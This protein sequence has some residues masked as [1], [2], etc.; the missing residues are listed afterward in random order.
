M[1]LHCRRVMAPR[2]RALVLALLSVATAAIASRISVQAQDAVPR[3]APAAA[4][5]V[6][7]NREI[8]PIL[9]N[10]CFAC[11]GPDEKARKTRFHFDSR[12]AA[13]IKDGVIVPGQAQDSLLIQ[14]ITSTDPEE[15]MPP[16]DSGRSLTDKQV[17]LLKRWIDEGAKWDTHWAYVPPG[18]IEPPAITHAGWAR[19][20]IDRF[21]AARLEHEGLEPSPEAD[22]ET[23][24]RRVTFDLTGLPPTPAETDAFLADQSPDAYEKVVTRLLAS[25]RYGEQMGRYWLDQARYGDTHGL[26]LDNE[27]S[28]WPY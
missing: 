3:G 24:L 25:P 26:H 2:L 10:N 11:H 16:P 12:D 18:R 23:L 22:R 6:S 9:S 8:L 7:F 1:G 21:I 27:R 19:T 28:M 20:P 4:A 15:R 13:F 14:H 5:P 17:D